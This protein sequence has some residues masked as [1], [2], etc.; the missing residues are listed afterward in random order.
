MKTGFLSLI[1]HPEHPGLVRASVHTDLPELKRKTDGSE[2]R[3]LARFRDSEAGLMHVQNAMHAA[4]VNR[5][6]RIYR[7]SL[8]KMIACVEADGLDH[9]RIWIDPKIPNEELEEIV[10]ETRLRKVSQRRFDLF[11]RI[12]GYLALLLLLLTSLKL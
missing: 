12:I 7:K 6:L 3:Y 2:I 4:L 1:T 5:D 8:A 9:E 11:W 10:T